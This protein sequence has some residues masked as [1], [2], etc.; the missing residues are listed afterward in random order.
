VIIEQLEEE[1]KE[2]VLETAQRYDDRISELTEKL[3]VFEA[4]ADTKNTVRETFLAVRHL[5]WLIRCS[6]LRHKISTRK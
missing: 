2:L 3:R 5:V 1:K 4:G 6:C